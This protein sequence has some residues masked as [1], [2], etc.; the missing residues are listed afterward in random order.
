MG[1]LNITFLSKR[2]A[3]INN[4]SFYSP[5]SD[6][7]FPGEL[8]QLQDDFFNF[9]ALVIV[10]IPLSKSLSDIFNGIPIS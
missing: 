7:V 9:L 1:A 3:S 6:N 8:S 5:I 10:S 2:F 4:T